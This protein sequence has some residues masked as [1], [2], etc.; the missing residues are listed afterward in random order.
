MRCSGVCCVLACRFLRCRV[1]LY[2]CSLC[3]GVF[4]RYRCVTSRCRV[5]FSGL[6]F[7]WRVVMSFSVFA[8]PRVLLHFGLLRGQGRYHVVEKNKGMGMRGFVGI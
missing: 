6:V 1:V 8:P 4:V 2:G 3:R 7:H 5:L